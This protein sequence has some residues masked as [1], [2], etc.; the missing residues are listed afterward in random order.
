MI[1]AILTSHSAA[2]GNT[3]LESAVHLTKEIRC[4]IQTLGQRMSKAAN[5]G[6]QLASLF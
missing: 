6:V 1:K 2:R 3:S 5:E 4:D